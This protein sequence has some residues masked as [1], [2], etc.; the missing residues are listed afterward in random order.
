MTNNLEKRVREHRMKL[1]PSF[2][3]FYNLNKLIYFAEF[4]DVEE[5]IATEKKIKSW[6]RKKKMALIK[7]INPEFKDLLR[8]I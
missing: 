7:S 8:G 5:A 4:N 6:T 1:A 3:S 2:T